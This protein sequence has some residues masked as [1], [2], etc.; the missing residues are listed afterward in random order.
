MDAITHLH[1][2]QKQI[3]VITLELRGARDNGSSVQCSET[4]REFVRVFN[5][6]LDEEIAKATSRQN[7][8]LVAYE[9]PERPPGG[10]VGRSVLA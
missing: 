2:I 6:D 10:Y 5:L 7:E 4:F 3:N 8:I 9:L 1:Q